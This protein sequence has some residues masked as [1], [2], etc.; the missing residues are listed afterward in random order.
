MP[1]LKTSKSATKRL[2]F[3][4]TGKLLRRHTT[5]Q[6]LARKKSKRTKKNSGKVENVS[7]TDKRKIARI[8][9]YCRQG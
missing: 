2:K 4:T 5:S 3:T 7:P 9:T 8:V 1:K 6:H